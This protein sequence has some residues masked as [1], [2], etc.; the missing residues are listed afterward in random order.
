MQEVNARFYS[1]Y[2]GTETN[3]QPAQTST[4]S[5]TISS[6]PTLLQPNVAEETDRLTNVVDTATFP[7]QIAS[8]PMPLKLLQSAIEI[9]EEATSKSLSGHGPVDNTA[10]QSS[11][12][13]DPAS[14]RS[15]SPD[16]S[17]S[18][19]NMLASENSS[20][21]ES[22]QAYVARKIRDQEVERPEGSSP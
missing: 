4:D 5:G 7:N 16:Y 8:S 1:F 3:V 12:S 18:L 9:I 19:I 2:S 21:G 22:V 15:Q 11:I 6:R 20:S 13:G 14:K 17:P 10:T